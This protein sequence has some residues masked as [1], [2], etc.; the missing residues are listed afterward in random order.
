MSMQGTISKDRVKQNGEV[1]TPDEIVNDMINLCDEHLK[2]VDELTYIKDVRL[3]PTCGNGAILVRILDRKLG[4][5][6][7]IKNSG[8]NWQEALLYAVASIYGIDITADNVVMSKRR[9]LE[10]IETGKTEVL[11]LNEETPVEWHSTGFELNNN[12]KSIIQLILDYNIQC[13]DTLQGKHY[14]MYNN[15]LDCW[16]CSPDLID[17]QHIYVTKTDEN[18]K[19]LPGYETQADT[20]ML[21]QWKF[22][23]TEYINRQIS[24][25]TYRLS[26][27][28]NQKL[29]YINTK[30]LDIYCEYKNPVD[31]IIADYNF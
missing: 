7:K 3:E 27:E 6:E 24:F 18:N 2:N 28:N 1:F 29:Y 26:V 12:I 20:L 4:Q 11:K 17:E 16:T 8:G 23:N 14:K 19:E 13:G 22:S 31:D 30:Q 10:V 5:V 25:D 15:N 9:M 21:T